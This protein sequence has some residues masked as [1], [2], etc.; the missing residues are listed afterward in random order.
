VSHEAAGHSKCL[1][2]AEERA[3]GTIKLQQRYGRKVSDIKAVS[4]NALPLSYPEG[5]GVEP[6]SFNYH[7]K[8]LTKRPDE[9]ETNKGA[10]SEKPELSG[11]ST[12]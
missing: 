12:I 5:P 8:T 6:G 7:L 1:S 3:H 9:K 10:E 11:R 4:V 2:R